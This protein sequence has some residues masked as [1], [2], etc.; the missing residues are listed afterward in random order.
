MTTPTILVTNDDGVEAEG[1]RALEEAMESLG[2]VVVV[3][4][5]SEQSGVGHGISL[6]N[7]LRVRRKGDARFSVSGTPADCVYFALNELLDETPDLC[8]SGINH[9]ANLADDLIYSGTVAG[10]REATLCDV[11]AV[12]VSLATYQ[13]ETFDVAAD[14]STKIAGDVLDRGLPRDVLLNVNVPPDADEETP[15]RVAKLGRRNYQRFVHRKN[16]PQNRPYFWLGSSELTFDD[17]PGSDC[18]AITQSSITVT[19]VH[20]DRTHYAFMRELR[21]WDFHEDASDE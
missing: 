3:A 18:N 14:F 19:P 7:P 5:D 8:V 10:A 17:I 20:L 1:L 4:P 15:T 9:G 13:A 6:H 11:P 2:D 12:A 16:D 21:E